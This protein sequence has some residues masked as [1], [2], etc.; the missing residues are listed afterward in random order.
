[1]Q[2]MNPSQTHLLQDTPDAMSRFCFDVAMNL[3][4]IG[5]SLVEEGKISCALSV[6]QDAVEAMKCSL[7]FNGDRAQFTMI[8]DESLSRAMT[9]LKTP[10]TPHHLFHLLASNLILFPFGNSHGEPTTQRDTHEGCALIVFNL[11]LSNQYIG[12]HKNQS[13]PMRKSLSL[14]CMVFSILRASRE[15]SNVQEQWQGLPTRMLPILI[16][17]SYCMAHAHTFL[18]EHGLA[19][20]CVQQL[21][22]ILTK[23]MLPGSSLPAPAA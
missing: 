9:A 15:Q 2:T 4:N 18:G 16:D 3:N 8:L 23:T 20:E 1:M 12:Y 10:K 5:V 7:K 17:V 11:A 13:A 19:E 6:F 14:C 22:T 21:N